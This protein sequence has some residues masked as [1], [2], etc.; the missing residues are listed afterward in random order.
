MK[1]IST[2]FISILISAAAFAQA[3]F[4]KEYGRTNNTEIGGCIRPTSDGGYIIAGIS[5]NDTV[6]LIKTNQFGD[7]TFYKT[8]RSPQPDDA[9]VEQTTDGGYVILSTWNSGAFSFLLIRTDAN[10]DTLWTRRYGNSNEDHGYGL[11]QTSDGGFILAGMSVTGT[12]FTSFDL[13]IIKLSAT[14]VI[15][16]NKIIASAFI[17]N[18]EDRANAIKQT[19]DHGYIIA[20][21]TASVGAGNR[22]AF[23]VKIDSAG[24]VVWKRTYGNTEDDEASDIEQLPDSGFIVT[25]YTTASTVSFAFLIR[26][27][28]NGDTLWTHTY[29][30]STEYKAYSVQRTPDGGFI[31]GGYTTSHVG[32]GYASGLLIKTYSSGAVQWAR[33]YGQEDNDVFYSVRRTTDGGYVA[34]G[35]TGGIFYS[36]GIYVVKTDANGNSGCFDYNL[37]LTADGLV[38]QVGIPTANFTASAATA[39]TVAITLGRGNKV[40]TICSQVCFATAFPV[41]NVTCNGGCDGVAT[42]TS[43]GTA[44]FTYLWS[45]TNQTGQTASALCAGNYT[46]TITDN[47]GCTTSTSVIITEPTALMAAGSTITNVSCNGGSDGSATVNPGGGTPPYNYLWSPAGGSNITATGLTV[48]TYTVTVTDGNGCTITSSATITE[49]TLLTA[50]TVVGTNATCATCTDGSAY[51]IANGGIPAYT[52]AWNTSPVQ[53]AFSATGLSPGNYTACVTDANGCSTC[54][55]VTITY[56]TSIEELSQ[57]A[58]SILPNPAHNILNVEWFGKLTNSRSQNTE[59]RMFDITGREVFGATLYSQL[60]TFNFQL[61][62]G[63]YFVKVFTGEKV[64]TQKLVVE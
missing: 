44:P 20:G 6:I 27:D 40:T 36:P 55:G 34:C 25:G 7:T 22:D 15:E 59:L 32:I 1:S 60:S 63:I 13:H 47:T 51:V 58:F 43:S 24:T 17:E 61:S 46:V 30:D 23:L 14:G 8:F 21:Y 38:A 5:P 57:N 26:T 19:L 42:A 12:S 9:R 48:G 54:S 11:S 18:F 62:P 35:V 37:P 52:Y 50:F 64:L 41:S 45:P 10:G 2:L 28:M 39:Y 16:W 33:V 53:T 56:P 49:P 31:V 3:T 29:G 4:Q